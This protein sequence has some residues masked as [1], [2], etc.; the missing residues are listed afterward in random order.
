M[1]ELEVGRTIAQGSGVVAGDAC[2]DE[3]RS[4]E[5]QANSVP[6]LRSFSSRQVIF[7]T[8]VFMYSKDNLSCVR[9][10]LGV[11]ANSRLFGPIVRD[12]EILRDMWS[13]MIA[14]VLRYYNYEE[15]RGHIGR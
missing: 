1:Q 4:A 7:V 13:Q 9:Q 3:E 15:E 11:F 2:P 12:L 14:T 10:S 8:L 5:A 6:S